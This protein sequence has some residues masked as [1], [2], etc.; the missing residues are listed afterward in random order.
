MY[1]VSLFHSTDC[2]LPAG[3]GDDVVE[4]S[5]VYR[6][7]WYP[8]SCSDGRTALG[9]APLVAMFASTQVRLICYVIYRSI[10]THL[11]FAIK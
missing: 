8:E 4:E 2:V 6:L 3:D 10:I 11:Y 7:Q 9:G 1:S 5:A